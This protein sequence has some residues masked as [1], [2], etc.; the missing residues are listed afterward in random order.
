MVDKTDEEMAELVDTLDLPI[1]ATATYEKW[2]KA[3]GE[4]LGMRYSDLL[5]ERTWRGV[6][7]KYE[8]LPELGLRM[9]R[10][11]H[12]EGTIGQFTQAHFRDLAT[13]RFIKYSV[14]EEMVRDWWGR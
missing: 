1:D 2:Q 4:E 11:V 14:V 6:E 3:L 9:E 13:G 7:T 12:Q 8:A 5:A 10:L